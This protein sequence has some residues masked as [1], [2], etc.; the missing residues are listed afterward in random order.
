[1][2]V[3]SL[4]ENDF[5]EVL[6]NHLLEVLHDY[7][8][9]ETNATAFSYEALLKVK[10]LLNTMNSE[11]DLEKITSALESSNFSKIAW[12]ACK[13]KE[14]YLIKSV[15]VSAKTKVESIIM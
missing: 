8:V 4:K 10:E 3:P 6:T 1:M 14:E 9:Q 13:P 2:A 12:V 15:I 5:W 11:E 7:V